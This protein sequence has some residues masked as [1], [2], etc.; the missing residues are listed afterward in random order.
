VEQK[1]FHLSEK[2]KYDVRPDSLFLR[3][4]ATEVQPKWS[5]LDANMPEKT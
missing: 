1:G 4:V 3:L 5:E 2:S